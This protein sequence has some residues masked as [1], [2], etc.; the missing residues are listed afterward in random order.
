MPNTTQQISGLNPKGKY[1]LSVIAKRTYEIN[2]NGNCKLHEVQDDII[3]DH[4][5]SDHVEDLFAQ[6]IDVYPCKPL[7]DI[8]LKGVARNE[9]DVKQFSASIELGV[10]AMKYEIFADRKVTKNEKG[11][12]IF[13][14]ESKIS[15]VPLLYTNAYGGKDLNAEKQLRKAMKDEEYLKY[16]DEVLDIFAGSPYRYPRNPLG[17]GYVVEAT[18]ETISELTLPNIE[19]PNQLLTPDN[20]ICE[21][22][23]EWHKMPVPLGTDWVHPGWFPR[24]AYFGNYSLPEGLSNNIYEIKN[25]LVDKSILKSSPDPRIDA[26]NFRAC[27]GASL[28]LQS[29]LISSGGQQCRLTN[30]H[31]NRKDFAFTLPNEIPNIKIDGRNGKLLNTDPRIQTILIEPELKK[32]TMVWRGSGKALRPYTPEELKSMPYEVIWP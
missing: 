26:F 9:K 24:V 31:P 5:M 1:I 30:I 16:V 27:N 4:V 10:L 32:L 29:K 14:N 13:S 6:D 15:E 23:L 19:N 25:N 22:V 12:Y 3:E 7:T 8:I 2:L 17:K 20:F 18:P 11:S 28:G 21:N